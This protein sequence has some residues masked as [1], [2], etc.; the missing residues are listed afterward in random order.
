MIK[1]VFFDIDGTLVSPITREIPDSARLAI[2]ALQYKGILCFAAT[3]RHPNNTKGIGLEEL[4]LDGIIGLNGQIA[5]DKNHNVLYCNALDKADQEIIAKTFNEG[6]VSLAIVEKDRQYF[7]F[8][9]ETAIAIR[10][11]FML[12]MPDI[13]TYNGA[14]ILQAIAYINEEDEAELMAK[15]KNCKSARW[16][17]A[18]ID[19]INKSGGKDVGI[20]KLINILGIKQEETMAFGDNY[21]D[22]DMLNF[23]HIGVSMGNGIDALKEAADYVTDTPEDGGIYNALKHFE[24]I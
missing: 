6:K 15:F 18:G 14:E 2:K 13:S 23:V 11:K 24:I 7:N 5:V 16:N 9:T 20:N 10:K 19:I 3:G 1:I 4:N 21:N 12:P 8:I 22:L 17:S